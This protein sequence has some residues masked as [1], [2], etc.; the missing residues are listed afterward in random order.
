MH[1]LSA[2][3]PGRE[4]GLLIEQSRLAIAPSSRPVKGRPEAVG[5]V[6]VEQAKVP[7]CI[8]RSLSEEGDLPLIQNPTDD[9]ASA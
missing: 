1:F 2:L 4:T 5:S 3:C 6:N 7:V 8:G 9:G